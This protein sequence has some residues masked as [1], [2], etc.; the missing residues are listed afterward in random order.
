MYTETCGT[1]WRNRQFGEWSCEYTLSAEISIIC[2]SSLLLFCEKEYT[3]A[4]RDFIRHHRGSKIIISKKPR[5]SAYIAVLNLYQCLLYAASRFATLCSASL[6][7]NETDKSMSYRT[8][9]RNYGRLGDH[10][11]IIHGGYYLS[12]GASA[13]DGSHKRLRVYAYT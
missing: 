13:H 8:I 6:I 12:W 5:L 2:I 4:M 3:L 9:T 11:V 10:K 1:I 7:N